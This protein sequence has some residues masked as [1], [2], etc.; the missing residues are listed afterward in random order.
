MSGFPWRLVSFDIDGT[1]TDGH[2]WKFLAERT[3]QLARFEESNTRYRARE[4]GEDAHLRDLLNLAAGLTVAEV[5]AILEVTPRVPGVKEVVAGLHDR[6]ARVVLLS[7]NPEYVC[8]WYQ[9]RFGFDDAEGTVAT[10]FDGGR[11]AP[12]GPVHTGKVEGMHRL[13][14]R[15]GVTAERAVHVGDGW[16]DIPVFEAV[17]GGIALNNA[18][19]V[20]RAA[21]DR[22]L[23]PRNLT[24][25]LPVLEAM[26]PRPVKTGRPA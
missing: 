3:G 13:L 6:G 2:G 25:L 23:A 11:I 24:E 12:Y 14:E 17:G 5:E 1:L 20:V 26:T 4:L 16:A 10:T 15:A 22:S 9:R 8:A 19:A 7:H 18:S 21:A